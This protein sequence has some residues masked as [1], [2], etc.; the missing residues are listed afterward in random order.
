MQCGLVYARGSARKG[1]V[2]EAVAGYPLRALRFMDTAF[3][4][5]GLRQVRRAAHAQAQAQAVGTAA[6][7]ASGPTG[8]GVAGSSA[9]KGEPAGWARGADAPTWVETRT[10][11]SYFLFDQVHVLQSQGLGRNIFRMIF[12]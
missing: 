10:K 2:V 8:E 5:A 4:R 6:A 3:E 9:A 7:P 12:L 11:S 1:G